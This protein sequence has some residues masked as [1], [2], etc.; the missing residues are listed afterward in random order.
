MVIWIH[1]KFQLDSLYGFLISTNYNIIKAF[2]L[3]CAIQLLITFM[4]NQ[5]MQITKAGKNALSCDI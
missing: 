4:E 1:K 2:L 3:L 5:K